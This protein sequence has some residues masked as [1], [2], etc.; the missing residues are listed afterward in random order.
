MRQSSSFDLKAAIIAI[1]AISA[2]CNAAAV[3]IY[4]Y[5]DVLYMTCVNPVSSR[6]LDEYKVSNPIVAPLNTC[7]KIYDNGMSLYI[8][9]KDCDDSEDSASY[10]LYNNAACTT[11]P[12]NGE[13]VRVMHTVR[14]HCIAPSSTGFPGIKG[15]RVT[16]SA[17]LPNA[18]SVHFAIVSVAAALALCL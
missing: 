12:D 5:S 2:L 1:L 8:M 17:V 14:N 13:C 11:C 16:C 3:N 4:A 9:Y 18:A 10:I 15:F 7:T 6:V